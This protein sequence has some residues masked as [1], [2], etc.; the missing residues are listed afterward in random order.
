MKADDGAYY[1]FEKDVNVDE[2]I[3]YTNSE[4]EAGMHDQYIGA[5]LQLPDKYVMKRMERFR[6]RLRNSDVNP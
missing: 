5:E 3:D 1:S 2:A 4:T 6:K